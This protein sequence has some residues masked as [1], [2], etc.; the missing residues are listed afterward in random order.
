[1]Q[2]RTITRARWTSLSSSVVTPSGRC[3]PSGLG[4]YT[5]PD[6]LRPV[7]SSSQA[8]GEV[9]EMCFELLSVG[10]PRLPVHPSCRV[11]LEAE[12][13]LTQGLDVVD[14]VQERREP[15]P[16]VRLRC[17]PYAVPRTGHAHP[18]LRPERVLRSRIP[19]GLP[20]SLHPLRGRSV[21]FHSAPQASLGCLRRFHLR[22]R[23]GPPW[24]RASA[25]SALVREL[26]RYYAAVRLP[27]PCIDGSSPWTSHRGP[28]R[29][30][31]R[32]VCRVSRFSRMMLPRMLGVS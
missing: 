13:S 4:M 32:A 30:P 1:M 2:F 6:R 5:L 27:A 14:V 16:L 17:L 18:A 23:L 25:S 11:P 29:H 31:P 9:D 7:R 21:G 12:V 24:P 15:S 10:P 20:P 28:R 22:A 19:L 26:R 8:F 3:R